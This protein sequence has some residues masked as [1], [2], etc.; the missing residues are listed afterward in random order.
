MRTEV[1]SQR[2][3]RLA[4]EIFLLSKAA[5]LQGTLLAPVPLVTGPSAL[6]ACGG[7]LRRNQGAFG[8]PLTEVEEKYHGN[9]SATGV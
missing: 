9:E 1:V 6:V 5:L 3:R 2:Y 4:A 7:G 8:E